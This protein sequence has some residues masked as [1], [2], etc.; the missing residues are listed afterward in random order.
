MPHVF[1]QNQS[2]DYDMGRK[3]WNSQWQTVEKLNL[4]HVILGSL[5][6]IFHGCWFLSCKI[7]FSKSSPKTMIYVST[8]GT[9]IASNSSPNGP[10]FLYGVDTPKFQD[11][12]EEISHQWG[13][14]RKSQGFPAVNQIIPWIPPNNLNKGAEQRV[15]YKKDCKSMEILGLNGREL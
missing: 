3:A 7:S 10:R 2:L 4:V 15:E 14:L 11:L 8:T 13:K 12:R 5:R 1:E 9:I 6:V